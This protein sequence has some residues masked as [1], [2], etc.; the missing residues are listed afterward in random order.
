MARALE[1]TQP[2]TPALG[3]ALSRRWPLILALLFGLLAA[4]AVNSYLVSLRQ[5]QQ[6]LQMVPVVVA[7]VDVRERAIIGADQVEVRQMPRV[8]V[9]PLAAAQLSQ[10][11]GRVASSDITAGEPILTSKLAERDARSGM[12]YVIPPGLRA[13]TIAVS[14]VKGVG[15]FIAPGDLVDVIVTLETPNRTAV[16][17]ILYQR[18]RVLATA[19]RV[20]DRPGER[21][22]V[23]SSITIAVTPQQAEKIVLADEEGKVRFA[24]RPAGDASYVPTSGAAPHLL[25]PGFMEASLPLSAAAGAPL[26][27]AAVPAGYVMTP[28]TPQTAAQPAVWQMQPVAPAQVTTPAAAP[29]GQAVRAPAAPVA[30]VVAAVPLPPPY[31]PPPMILQGILTR[32]DGTQ[33]VAVIKMSDRVYVV[34]P[35][36]SLADGLLVVAVKSNQVVLRRG[37]DTFILSH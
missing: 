33:Q 34:T 13:I 16:T 20:E 25:V 36:E 23:V 26:R 4:F 14:E 10:V 31:Q 8:Y 2:R 17:K 21:P 11:V 19:Q 28:Y 5:A 18:I 1:A 22:Q 30:P 24:L 6:Q 32:G 9:H 12:A 15:G 3:A 29:A 37:D 7:R 35:G 27:P